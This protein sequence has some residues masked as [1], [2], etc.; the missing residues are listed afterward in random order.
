MAYV[1]SSSVVT[2]TPI[3]SNQALS[4]LRR[5]GLF[6]KPPIRK[7]CG[8]NNSVI[9]G[10]S[11]CLGPRGALLTRTGTDETSKLTL[12]IIAPTHRS[13]NNC[14]VD[15]RERSPEYQ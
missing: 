8:F 6:P 1:A 2:W 9:Y 10:R 11:V 5:Y 12:V 13:K 14:V 3:G 4:C 15:L 7:M